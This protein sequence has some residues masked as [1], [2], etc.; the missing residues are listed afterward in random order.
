MANYVLEILD[1]D[2]AGDVIPVGASPV[3]IGRKPANDI[4]LADEKT[5]GVHCE[6]TPED[7]RPVLKDLG[8]TNGTFLDG[9]RVTEVVLTDGDVVTVGRLRVRFQDADAAAGG[10]AVEPDGEFSLRKLDASRLQKRGSSAGL[11]GIL[12]LLIVGGAGYW[13]WQGRASAGGGGAAASASSGA[14]G[15]EGA[16]APRQIKPLVVSGNKLADGIGSFEAEEIEGWQLRA[17]GRAWQISGEAHSGQGALSAFRAAAAEGGE[18]A[19]D[20][21]AGNP[22][23][24]Q[25]NDEPNGTPSGTPSGEPNYAVLRLSEPLQVFAGRSLTVSAFVTTRGDAQIALRTIATSSKEGTPFRFCSGTQMAAYDGEWQELQT[26][27]TMPSGCD[28]LQVE[29]V[30]VLPNDDSEAIVDDLAVVEGGDSNAI[31]QLLESGGQ[32]V[33]GYGAS[34]A[35]RST[36]MDA[37]VTLFGMHPASAPA[38]LE[39]LHRDGLCELSDLGASVAIDAADPAV[40]LTANGLDGASGLQLV[41][42]ADAAAG[43]MA[44]GADK[45]FASAAAASTFTAQHIL[46]GSFATRVQIELDA[47]SECRGELREGLYYL[48]VPAAAPKLLFGFR[49]ERQAAAKLLRDASAA[50]RDGQPGAALDALRELVATVP[51]D[52]EELAA[53]QQLRADLLEEQSSR[54]RRLQQGLEQADFFDTR[55]GFE[56]VRAGVDE[57]VGLYGERN[58]KGIEGI[59]ELRGT[60]EERLA[61]LDRTTHT[62][63]RERLTELSDAFATAAKPGLAKIVRAYMDEHLKQ[64]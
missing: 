1:G 6:I 23:G 58:L 48:T 25:A 46:L 37:P 26:T 12:L 15:G 38:P 52:S 7:G 64:D 31:D 40:T 61:A 29:V 2:R 14:G 27:A 13:W 49:Q 35:V 21:V 43:L 4:V 16:A 63:Q 9:K 41:L 28:R 56:R 57:L 59:A 36:D 51:M 22:G 18:A 60:A 54:F 39:R 11:L 53:A 20:S 62:A 45:R 24:G 47:E 33:F 50:R 55:G 10:G 30:A 32:T 19:G 42:P 3:R 5:S 17:A 44:A 8:S 34:V